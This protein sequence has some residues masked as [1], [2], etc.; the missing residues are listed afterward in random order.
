MNDAIHIIKNDQLKPCPYC[1]NIPTL[2]QYAYNVFVVACERY[3]CNIPCNIIAFDETS[4]I[5]S[6]N[7]LKKA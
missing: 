4:A 2:R 1:G 6:W 5:D 7:K 3:A